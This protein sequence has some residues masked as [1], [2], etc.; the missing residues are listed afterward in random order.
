MQGEPWQAGPSDLD[1]RHLNLLC[2]LCPAHSGV[3]S[4]MSPGAGCMEIKFISISQI[5]H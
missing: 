5:I 3:S 2:K 1:S 4:D